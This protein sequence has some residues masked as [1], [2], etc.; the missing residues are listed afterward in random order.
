MIEAY[1]NTLVNH[2][3]ATVKVYRAYLR[4]LQDLLPAPLE[5]AGLD[6]LCAALNRFSSRYSSSAYAVCKAALRG[7]LGY[8][9]RE[10]LRRRIRNTPPHWLPRRGP[11]QE[12]LDSVLER[13]DLRERAIILTLYS[14]GARL[15]E[16]FGNRA[17]KRPPARV[18]DID[19][20]A[21]TIRVIQ[22]GGDPGYVAFFLRRTEAL[23]TLRQFLGFRTRGPIF[24][25]G[26]NHACR[27][28]RR[29]G[30]RVGLR[31]TPHLLRHACVR[32]M[33]EQGIDLFTINSQLRHRKLEMTLRYAQVDRLELIRLAE[34]TEWR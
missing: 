10:D 23:R 8:L 27:L 12:E 9:G 26:P 25:I 21:G 6:D 3:P 7:F 18:E 30:A 29:A 17:A 15:G 28:V 13:C 1:L 32:S 2:S 22:K 4:M 14:T 5:N 33:R 16:I 11:T 31:L 34:K 24:E 19:W 20:R